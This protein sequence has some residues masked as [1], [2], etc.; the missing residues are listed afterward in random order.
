MKHSHMS[1]SLILEAEMNSQSNVSASTLAWTTVSPPIIYLGGGICLP[2]GNGRLCQKCTILCTINSAIWYG[3]W[4]CTGKP[5]S[6]LLDKSKP[7]P[8]SFSSVY[9]QDL[10]CTDPATECAWSVFMC[11][12]PKP[13]PG[14]PPVMCDCPP[15]VEKARCVARQPTQCDPQGD[16]AGQSCPYG[17]AV[18]QDGCPTCWCRPHP[19]KPFVWVSCRILFPNL[20]LHPMNK[21]LCFYSLKKLPIW[22]L[23]NKP[24]WN[25]NN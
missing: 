15:A 8:Q 13:I 6:R 14:Q 18:D 3:R 12:C 20:Q 9:W 23:K 17:Y 24:S 16:C 4:I 2:A 25:L 21:M 10:S 11:R 1:T 22:L 7:T 19:M 5:K